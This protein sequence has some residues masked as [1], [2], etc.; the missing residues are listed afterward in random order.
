M[1]KKVLIIGITYAI[2]ADSIAI[3]FLGIWGFNENKI[4]NFWIYGMPIDDLLFAIVL[5]QREKKTLNF[6]KS[7]LFFFFYLF[8]FFSQLFFNNRSYLWTNN[9][10][11][12]GQWNLS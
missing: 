3:K 9:S 10:L 1:L 4:T 5:Y 7:C 11:K 6:F 8:N 2:I 12:T